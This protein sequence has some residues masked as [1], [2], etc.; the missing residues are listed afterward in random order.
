LRVAILMLVSGL[1]VAGCAKGTD[2]SAP[3]A[4]PPVATTKADGTVNAPSQPKH[5][6]VTPMQTPMAANPNAG[7][8]LENGQK[9]H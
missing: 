1:L 6:L 9:G 7:A 3:V 2:K 4:L 8:P 5:G